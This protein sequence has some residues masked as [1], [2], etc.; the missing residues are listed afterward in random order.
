MNAEALSVESVTRGCFHSESAVIE[1]VLDNQPA[2]LRIS[3]SSG[4][5]MAK[6]TNAKDISCSEARQLIDRF[7]KILTTRQVLAGDRSTTTFEG[8]VLWDKGNTRT[9]WRT[10]S[11]E[12][13]IELVN[14]LLPKLD[15]SKRHALESSREGYFNV[16]HELHKA[17]IAVVE[18]HRV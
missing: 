12:A 8:H 9:E 7:L 1:I 6:I 17:A 3:Q 16:A 13:P 11:S 10:Y 14:E 18:A 4:G 15:A 2:V 5:P